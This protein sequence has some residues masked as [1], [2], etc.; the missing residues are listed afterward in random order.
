MNA[1]TAILLT[2]PGAAAIAVVRLHGPQVADLLARS[3]SRPLQPNRCVHGQ[4][5]DGERVLDDPVV[6]LHDDGQTADLSL[7]G[8]PWIVRC[9]LQWAERNGFHVIHSASKTPLPRQAVDAGDDLTAEVLM[10]LPRARTELA[11]R[12]LLNQPQAWQRLEHQP[13]DPAEFRRMLEDRSLQNL[14]RLPTVAILG[15]PNAGKSTLAN[16]LFAQERA[17][18]A[19]L[20]G[21]TRD[22]VGEIA[23]IDGL[24]VM[25][26]DTPGLRAADD[27]IEAAAIDA[28]L[29]PIRSAD[30]RLLVLDPTQ[31]LEPLQQ[32]LIDAYP[33]A[34][35]IV[36]KA[37]RPA[38]WTAPDDCLRTIAITDEGIAAV[39][40]A[41]LRH[42]GCE[43]LD[44]TCPRIWTDR[45]RALISAWHTRLAIPGKNNK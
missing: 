1:A 10:H 36:N 35:R 45:Q 4:L 8:G 27:P 29:Q 17:I 39:R 12:I 33:D 38:L 44:P 9:V 32:P 6:V 25:L 24:A 3:F 5:R 18:T 22:W 28:S 21:T 2:P 34:I 41:I 19:D 40:S 23:N 43:N 13:P 30:L 31:P 20:P 15:A 37:D 14:L 7:H 42:F 16:R 11:I 26:V